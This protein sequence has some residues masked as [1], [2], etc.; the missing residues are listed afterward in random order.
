MDSSAVNV[1]HDPK[2]NGDAPQ[3]RK[4]VDKGPVGGFQRDLTTGER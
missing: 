3:D 4:A 1:K 2:V